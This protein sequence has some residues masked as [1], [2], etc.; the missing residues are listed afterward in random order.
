MRK[1]FGIARYTFIEI[2]RNKVYYV[3]LL[4][5]GVLLGAVL[6]LGAL[7][8]E[9]RNRMIIDFGL[10]SI[11]FFAL[12]IAVFAAV[13]LVLEEMESRT[14]YLILSR[15]VARYQFVLGRF[16]GLLGVLTFAY[17]LMAA[18]HAL[19]LNSQDIHLHAWY[20]LSLLYSWEKIV[21]ITAIGMAF[22]LFATSTISAI[23]F[24]LFF[25]VMGHFSSEIRFLAGK[26]AQPLLTLLFNVFYYLTPNFQLMNLKDLPSA[27][28]EG[29]AWLWSAA[30]YGFAYTVACLALV[31][32]LFRKKE[33]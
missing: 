17:L 2:F 30:G 14:L 3:L 4:F 21:L 26:A 13:T 11:E 9:Q 29:S 12:L 1:I 7:G 5:A 31:V 16:L 8:G 6:L 28:L 33:F 19:L 32:L 18:G 22:S 15:P 25:W 20:F 27:P 24:T 23:A 10:V